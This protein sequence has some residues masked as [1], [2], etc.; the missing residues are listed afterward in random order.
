M[1]KSNTLN[2]LAIITTLAVLVTILGLVGITTIVHATPEKL[3]I[4][5]I[6]LNMTD[7]RINVTGTPSLMITVGIPPIHGIPTQV[8]EA[9]YGKNIYKLFLYNASPYYFTAG[10][11]FKLIIVNAST[12]YYET[13]THYFEIYPTP[14][15]ITVT[16]EANS[17]GGV[18][19]VVKV[20]Q[21][22]INLIAFWK[23]IILVKA[24]GKWWLA[25]NFTTAIPMPLVSVL[26]ILSRIETGK[27]GLPVI[28]STTYYHILDKLDTNDILANIYINGTPYI[29]AKNAKYDI[30]IYIPKTKYLRLNVTPNLPYKLSPATQI[31]NI[32]ESAT[33]KLLYTYN[34]YGLGVEEFPFWVE[35]AFWLPYIQAFFIVVNDTKTY[36]NYY[37]ITV[38][39]YL[40]TGKQVIYPELMYNETVTNMIGKCTFGPIYYTTALYEGLEI[41]PPPQFKHFRALVVKVQK[42][43]SSVYYRIEIYYM[44]KLTG[45]YMKT[46]DVITKPYSLTNFGVIALPNFTTLKNFTVL[47]VG[48]YGYAYNP[49]AVGIKYRLQPYAFVNVPKTTYILD[50]SKLR[51]LLGTKLPTELFNMLSYR[52]YEVTTTGKR[53]FISTGPENY[54]TLVGTRYFDIYIN[55]S[56]IPK[57]V[58]RGPSFE[59]HHFYVEIY[60]HYDMVARFDITKLVNKTIFKM[61]EV[62][63]PVS[64]VILKTSIVPVVIRIRRYVP[65]INVTAAPKLSITPILYRNMRVL[66]YRS[67]YIAAP[68]TLYANLS[69]TFSCDL[70]DAVAARPTYIAGALQL[71][72]VI[73][74]VTAAPVEYNITSLTSVR[75]IGPRTNETYYYYTVYVKYG[76]ITIGV[77]EFAVGSY[78]RLVGTNVTAVNAWV[79]P[80]GGYKVLNVYKKSK[81]PNFSSMWNRTN[82]FYTVGGYW[83]GQAFPYT[84][85]VP[86]ITGVTAEKVTA[87]NLLVASA[88]VTVMTYFTTLYGKPLITALPAGVSATVSVVRYVAGKPEVIATVPARYVQQLL[89]PVPVTFKEGWPTVEKTKA[90]YTFILNYAGYTLYAVNRTTGKP[91]KLTITQL[92]RGLTWTEIAFPIV[93]E[94]FKVESSSGVPLP[95]FVIQVFSTKTGEELWR[96]ITNDQGLAYIG[97]L[98]ANRSVIVVVR[99]IIPKDDKKWFIEH[100]NVNRTLAEYHNNYAEYASLILGYKPTEWVYTLGT[101][102]SL[103]AGLVANVTKITVPATVGKNIALRIVNIRKVPVYVVYNDSGKLVLLNTLPVYPCSVP[104][105][106]PVILY[107]LTLVINGTV[108]SKSSMANLVKLAD[109]RM[110]GM[111]WAKERYEEL[112]KSYRHDA[113]VALTKYEET[114]EDAW[115]KDYMVNMSYYVAAALIAN[116]SSSTPYALFYISPIFGAG[117]VWRVIL[118]GQTYEAQVYYLGYKVFDNVITIPP[119]NMTYI[120][121]P[122]GTTIN[123]TKPITL[124]TMTGKKVTVK[125]GS[126]V[127]VSTVKPVTFKLYTR[128][129]ETLR[130]VFLGLLFADTL[131]RTFTVHTGTA[132]VN[133]LPIVNGFNTTNAIV[134]VPSI[135]G[136]YE[137]ETYENV[138]YILP[139]LMAVTGN[140]KYMPDTG[141]ELLPNGSLG[142]NMTLYYGMLHLVVY[143]NG[144][145]TILNITSFASAK[146]LRRSI[147]Y[148][149]PLSE[150]LE[151]PYMI[152]KKTSALVSLSLSKV[153]KKKLIIRNVFKYDIGAL[154]L[155]VNA[156]D[157]YE[158]TNLT[159]SMIA[160]YTS[161]G[162]LK[163]VVLVSPVNI[164]KAV[165][166]ILQTPR[167]LVMLVPV[168]HSKIY[169]IEKRVKIIIWV[170]GTGYGTLNITA[171]IWRGTPFN[172]TETEVRVLQLPNGTVETTSLYLEK[173]LPGTAWRYYFGSPL[174][175][176]VNVDNGVVRIPLPEWTITTNVLR[177]AHIARIYIINETPRYVERNITC[178]PTSS[179][180]VVCRYW[181]CGPFSSREYFGINVSEVSGVPYL[182]VKPRTYALLNFARMNV[183][184]SKV[185]V[186]L[187]GEA[188]VV[189]RKAITLGPLTGATSTLI[190][191]YATKNEK[192]FSVGVMPSVVTLNSI[193][194]T[195]IRFYNNNTF[196][197]VVKSTTKPLVLPSKTNKTGEIAYLLGPTFLVNAD[198]VP[199]LTYKSKMFVE[200]VPEP[201]I[202]Y[203]YWPP[204][205]TFYT[206][207][208]KKIVV[209][210]DELVKYEIAINWTTRS[211]IYYAFTVY[212]EPAVI[213]V[214][215]LGVKVKVMS[216]SGGWVPVGKLFLGPEAI[217]GL[218]KVFGW[219]GKPIVNA[220]VVVFDN[221]S[222]DLCHPMAITFI[223]PNG[224]LLSVLPYGARVMIFWYDSYVRYLFTVCRPRGDAPVASFSSYAVPIVIYDSAKQEDV[225]KLGNAQQNVS[226]VYTWVYSLVLQV[227]TKTGLPLKNAVVVV[228]DAATGGQYFYASAILNSTGGAVIRDIRTAFA[229]S[230]S[231][232][233]A[234]NLLVDVFIPITSGGKTYLV[235]VLLNY[236]LSLQRGSTNPVFVT[237]VKVS[238]AYLKIPVTVQLQVPGVVTE[239]LAGAKVEVTEYVP[240]VT[241]ATY[242]PYIV[243]NMKSLTTVKAAT[244]TLT[245]G[246][247]GT[248]TVSPVHVAALGATKLVVKVLSV[249]GLPL[250]YEE[251]YELTPSSVVTPVI[252]IPGA[253]V[254]VL[255]VSASGSP[256]NIASISVNCTYGGKVIYTGYGKGKLSFILPLPKNVATTPITCVAMATAPGNVKSKTYTIEISKPTTYELKVKVPVTGWWWPGVGYVSWQ[257]IALWIVIIFIVIII[258]V[259]GLIEYQHWR[260]KR[261]VS[262]LG[263]PSQR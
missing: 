156:S 262:V 245:T 54:A 126:I 15:N 180:V 43:F 236:P 1:P 169:D 247:S 71:S 193:P 256:L 107:N 183:N 21:S 234:S 23:I 90:T 79:W 99:T 223:G 89:I 124:T 20:P 10:K 157:L 115:L 128:D 255:A 35:K 48:L 166:K 108:Y 91:V 146:A 119:Y 241:Y 101:R 147:P 218:S 260:R 97:A 28:N 127:I 249:N 69:V 112:A 17:T 153:E 184:V 60:Y 248:V 34:Y 161:G 261:L 152:Y 37:K 22:I 8:W 39:Q 136:M 30:Y 252:T 242:G 229:G 51:S 116:A 63:F 182:I 228:K 64:N 188:D 194:E 133:V 40:P 5:N 178:F 93:Y 24:W 141:I 187:T 57:Y 203:K 38:T 212:R 190:Y 122:N 25:A 150:L 56:Y 42:P 215:K 106:C 154:Y 230:V 83:E 66:I 235:P 80:V 240:A 45:E 82:K 200:Y 4:Y 246:S 137:N 167:V 16:A 191:N 87:V 231:S 201:K 143:V 165:E 243:P 77:G 207:T 239:P 59:I 95:G 125:P 205:Y 6:S 47:A 173:L 208:M 253:E 88:F 11:E 220:T 210:P 36:C 163:R 206:P 92:L 227:L 145:P 139:S 135:I 105:R 84:S 196:D 27:M 138:T 26:R 9:L 204:S 70:D 109:F 74:L 222:R 102:A 129:N 225:Q 2:R 32:Y 46:L 214:N 160:E 13:T 81:I 96:A 18:L 50:T 52:W 55:E 14:I 12:P 98:P 111:N 254:K 263:P 217:Y 131:A 159:V 181:T 238:T 72:P 148:G 175:L 49:K 185:Y 250:G 251:T 44:T 94:W 130:H 103:D 259:I 174:L 172:I 176:L 192:L 62:K 120:V 209:T 216:V 85:T 104:L 61:T 110:I 132:L 164:T 202:A 224:S 19:F 3:L 257:Q 65:G 142:I 171:G 232:V 78:S 199:C 149:L 219:N 86:V 168:N 75:I 114:G 134:G 158:I 213:R 162:E 73:Y 41:L 7:A 244:W 117:N 58:Y 226:L 151:A 113:E 53:I 118:P 211:D 29:V 221:V 177:G 155:M 186:G 76:P 100:I 140:E 195:L 179:G 68:G 33:G 121:L 31:V 123:V 233:P 144:K 258:I 67:M 170:N 197:I 237:T 198:A 189:E